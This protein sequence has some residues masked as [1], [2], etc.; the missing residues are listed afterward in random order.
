MVDRSL[1]V[2]VYV[3]DEWKCRFCKSRENLTPHHLIHK[4]QGGED[5]LDNLVTLCFNCHRLIHD[6]KLK[7]VGTNSNKGLGFSICKKQ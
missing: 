1:A 5:S 2:K 3:R 7:I 4:S 6:G